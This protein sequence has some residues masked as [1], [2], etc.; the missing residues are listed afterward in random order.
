MALSQV[1]DADWDEDSFLRIYLTTLAGTVIQMQV[2]VSIHHTWEMLE[3]YLV[4]HLPRNSLIETFGCEL[5]LLDA[6]TQIALQDPIQEDLWKNNQFCLVVHDCVRVLDNNNLS[7]GSSTMT[8]AIRVP[9]SELGILEAKAFHSTA[10]VRH[11][12]LDVGFYAIS[13]QAWRY[14]HSLR[15]VKLPETVVTLGYAT[16][17]GCYSLQVAEMPGCVEF[18]VRAFAECCALERVGNIV[19][20]GS[21]LAIGAI[22]SQYA[23]E[24]CAKL[25]HLSLPQVRA[26]VDSGTFTSPQAGLPQGCFFASGIQQVELGEDTFHIGHRAFESCKMLTIVNLSKTGIH[27]LHMHTFAQCL[28]LHTIRRGQAADHSWSLLIPAELPEGN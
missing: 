4:E 13:P 19:D 16:F 9:V 27:T 7:R 23:F 22:I 24:E 5:T 6:D 10:R 1:Q 8:E 11:A 18:G 20:G 15:I 3:E 17:Q 2:P 14:C 26:V 28:N 12:Y 25:A 21:H